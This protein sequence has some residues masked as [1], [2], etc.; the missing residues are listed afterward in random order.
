MH[1]LPVCSAHRRNNIECDAR[2]RE[3]ALWVSFG[4]QM[5]F[6][7]DIATLAKDVTLFLTPFLPY[8]LKAGEKAV[9]EAGTKLGGEA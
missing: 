2:L 7:M 3:L 6:T 9:E 1:I 4:A 8:L 5:R